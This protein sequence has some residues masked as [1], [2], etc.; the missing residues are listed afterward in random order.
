MSNEK[1]M[2]NFGKIGDVLYHLVGFKTKGYDFKQ[3]LVFK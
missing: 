3:L 1:P 2:I